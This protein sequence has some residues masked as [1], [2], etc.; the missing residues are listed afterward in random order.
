M[1]LASQKSRAKTSCSYLQEPLCTG[2]SDMEPERSV[3][4]LWTVDRDTNLGA[5]SHNITFLSISMPAPI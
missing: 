1:T 4:S 3:P 5:T 2:S